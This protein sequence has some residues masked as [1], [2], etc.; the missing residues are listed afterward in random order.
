MYRREYENRNFEMEKAGFDRV[1]AKSAA[2]TRIAVFALAAAMMFGSVG[3]SLKGKQGQQEGDNVQTSSAAGVTANGATTA[4][5]KDSKDSKNTKSTAKNNKDNKSNKN[6]K[7]NSKNTSNQNSKNTSNKN[8]KAKNNSNSG[9]KNNKNNKNNNNTN[10]GN[11]T[12]NNGGNTTNNKKVT[13]N[14]YTDNYY[15]QN[16]K[17]NYDNRIEKCD[18]NLRNNPN[19]VYLMY[20]IAQLYNQ[21]ANQNITYNVKNDNSKNIY[22]DLSKSEE[23]YIKVID[24]IQNNQNEYNDID[25]N[26]VQEEYNSVVNTKNDYDVNNNTQNNTE[27]TNTEINTE[28][29][30][31]VNTDI[32]DETN[33]EINNTETNTEINNT[34]ISTDIDNSETNTQTGAEDTDKEDEAMQAEG[35]AVENDLLKAAAGDQSEETEEAGLSSETQYSDT[36]SGEDAD[37]GTGYESND[38]DYGQF[39][40]YGGEDEDD[41]YNQT[42]DYEDEDGDYGQFGDYTDEVEDQDYDPGYDQDEDQDYDQD[43]DQNYDQD[44]DQDYDLDYEENWDS[45]FDGSDANSGAGLVDITTN[46]MRNDLTDGYWLSG[47]HQAQVFRFDSD[48]SVYYAG[49]AAME[50]GEW[51]YYLEDEIRDGYYDVDGSTVTMHGDSGS[52]S[53]FKYVYMDGGYDAL[54]TDDARSQWNYAVQDMS[55]IDDKMLYETGFVADDDYSPDV[56][57]YVHVGHIESS[58]GDEEA[59]DDGGYADDEYAND[60]YVNGDYVNGGYADDFNEEFTEELNPQAEYDQGDDSDWAEEDG[61]DYGFYVDEYQPDEYV[62]VDYTYAY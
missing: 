31:E 4:K 57:C 32:S 29:N 44:Y 40:I 36:E 59:Y 61:S 54:E 53:T 45:G 13:N 6:S 15:T 43:Y 35:G 28:V 20:E 7:N 10:S 17:I 30:Q 11:T 46:E 58:S 21:R 9:N 55:S 41:Y 62:D 52:S 12:H 2:K 56:A 33:T 22:L 49:T 51:V 34:E 39:E 42:G 24:I 37:D 5:G 8:N 14:Y 25:I 50:N 47:M 26:T 18:K 1:N 16:Y 38:E 27:I 23:Y 3:C 60:D 48:G 19:D